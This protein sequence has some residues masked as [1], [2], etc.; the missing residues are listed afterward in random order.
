MDLG[1]IA[2]QMLV[3]AENVL[4]M[5]G[6]PLGSAAIIAAR[7]VIGMIDNTKAVFA[8]SDQA[9]LQSKRDE[10]EAAVMAHADRTI[11]SLD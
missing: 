4:P 1:A 6:G 11:D 2:K 8:E 7:G 3:L 5:V 10:L 9:A